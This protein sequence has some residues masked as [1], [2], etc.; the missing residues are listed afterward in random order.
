MFVNGIFPLLYS[1]VTSIDNEICKLLSL[2]VIIDAVS[3]LLLPYFSCLADTFFP[4][5]IYFA[6]TIYH[7]IRAVN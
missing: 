1:D 7:H 4:N 5:V 2:S 6:F 3:V